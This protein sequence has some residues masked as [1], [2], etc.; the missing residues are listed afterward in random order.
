[1]RIACLQ[2]VS[3]E[4][5][6]SIAPWA[7]A[8]GHRFDVVRLYEGQA[9]PRV[10]D[11]EWAVVMG[12]PMSVHDEATCL[13]LK[14]EK[15]WIGQLIGR[16][17]IVLGICLG[18]QLLA[19]VLGARVFPGAHKEVGWFPVNKT[20]EVGKYSVLAEA[21][22]VMTPFHWH[23]ETF[24]IPAGAARA[25]GSEACPNQAFVY[26]E[27]IVALQFHME[28]TPQ[29]VKRLVKNCP[30]DLV[31]GPFVQSPDAMIE[32]A[33]AFANAQAAMKSV[34]NQLERLGTGKGDV[35]A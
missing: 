13:W 2:H 35:R 21:P 20:A 19:E 27:R 32:N 16:G 18:A 24:D 4:D 7:E 9:L 23:G 1:M 25:F 17:G 10:S 12:G 26:R 6:G 29:G 30:G 28:M 34:L 22:A 11:V 14:A 31:A 5:A 3:F 33:A 8:R 15:D